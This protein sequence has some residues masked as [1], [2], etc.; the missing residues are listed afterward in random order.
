MLWPALRV[1]SQGE[2]TSDQ[3]Q[4]LLGT[5]RLE[6]TPR[7]E[8]P[9]AATI[10]ARSSVMTTLRDCSPGSHSSR[11]RSLSSRRRR[12]VARCRRGI[13]SARRPT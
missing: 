12:S 13:G 1:L 4:Q 2:L 11:L 9:G 6:Q 3:L 5:L 7:T 8:G 10:I